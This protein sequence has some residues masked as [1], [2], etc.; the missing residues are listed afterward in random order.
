MSPR[1]GLHLA[2][3]AG[4]ICLGLGYIGLDPS[5]IR[6]DGRHFAGHGIHPLRCLLLGSLKPLGIRVF[7]GDDLLGA[8]I[9]LLLGQAQGLA[10]FVGGYAETGV[11]FAQFGSHLDVLLIRVG[12]SGFLVRQPAAERVGPDQ[13]AGNA[14][15]SQ[16]D[17]GQQCT[18]IG[19]RGGIQITHDLSSSP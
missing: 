11:G 2:D 18:G 10:Q 8:A 7:T 12:Q 9:Q 17:D 19:S 15:Q 1:I 4:K 13:A 6:L 5:H 3:S 14:Q 16:G